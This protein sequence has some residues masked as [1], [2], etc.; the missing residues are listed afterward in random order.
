M[1]HERPRL[2]KDLLSVEEVC[3]PVVV[4]LTTVAGVVVLVLIMI[5]AVVVTGILLVSVVITISHT[6][7][8][9]HHSRTHACTHTTE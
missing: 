8:V 5:V 9:S 1:K 7:S 6:L 4:M 2:A 3:V